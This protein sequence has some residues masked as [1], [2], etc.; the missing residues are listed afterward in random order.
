MRKRLVVTSIHEMLW[1]RWT[2][3][4]SASVASGVQIQAARF[5]R[6]SPEASDEQ[7][8]GEKKQPD[9]SAFRNFKRNLRHNSGKERPG[10]LLERAEIR[11]M[12]AERRTNQTRRTMSHEG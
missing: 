11:L 8:N 10:I 7:H 6:D 2:T 12:T 1:P 3:G 9:L 4:M 5:P